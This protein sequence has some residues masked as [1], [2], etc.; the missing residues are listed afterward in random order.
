MKHK[1]NQPANEPQFDDGVSSCNDNGLRIM[2]FAIIFYVENHS[3]SSV[4]L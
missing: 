2:R 3:N 1:N 4:V